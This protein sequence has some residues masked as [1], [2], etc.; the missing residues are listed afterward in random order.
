VNSTLR[1]W[2]TTCAVAVAATTLSVP[3]AAPAQAAAPVEKAVF[4]ADAD[5]DGY[6]GL[7]V[8]TTPAGA[9]T[10]VVAESETSDVSDV[11]ASADGS[12]YVYQ[13]TTFAADGEPL[14][15]KMIVRDVSGRVVRVVSD[16][17]ASAPLLIKP[18]TLSPDGN[19]VLFTTWDFSA[20]V[21]VRLARASVS[22]GVI[23]TV[24]NDFEKG[25]FLNN[26]TV[27]A[28]AL[29]GEWR[30]MPIAGGTPTAVT[31]T[32]PADAY[33]LVV[34]P[35]GDKVAW[36]SDTS[37]GDI[38][39]SD[40]E[41][42]GLS[43]TGGVA[44]IGSA[45]TV[46]TGLDNIQPAFS[47]DG[48]TLSWIKW[49]GDFGPGDVWSSAVTSG[50]PAA[51]PATAG[52]DYDV[53]IVATDDGTAPGSVT[54]KP[55]VLN[56]PGATLS[57]TL[58]S[59]TD[60]SGVVLTRKLGTT[61]QKSVYLPGAVSSYGDTGLALGS[62]YTYELRAVDR[63]GNSTPLTHSLT[64]LKA[65]P[66]VAD[67]ISTTSAK[68]AFPVTFAAA[69]PGNALFYVDY[70]PSGSSTW[71]KWV[72]GASGRARTFGAPAATNVAA[73]TATPGKSYTFR[74]IVKDAFGNTTKTFVN[75]ARAVVPFDQTK[76]AFS[77]GSN[78][79]HSAAYLGSY[80]KLWR[81]TDYA[82]VTLTGNRIQVVG[83]RCS[84][85]GT[86]AIYDNGTLVGTVSSYASTTKVRQVLFAKT[87]S[88]IGT[89]S[90]TIK[91][92]ATAGRPNVMLDGFAIRN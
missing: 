14:R 91:P 42:A 58:P 51:T 1:R 85:C 66:T 62:T 11:S 74:V 25:V 54:W 16:V 89:H 53:A 81:T 68:A 44:T 49:D 18:P 69:A 17:S 37:A 60:L 63:S 71:V 59:V 46:A 52:D 56:G 40:I 6:Y 36:S 50:T 87:Y 73:T 83:W 29:T 67:P 92:K 88:A 31:G 3:L 33:D 77:G 28:Q 32:I 48:L 65:A 70:V 80:R 75:S 8:R 5:G 41:V 57:W 61:V 30:T 27:L 82:K 86:F 43:M 22:T 78:V 20:S 13:Q 35:A 38:S 23:G 10:A 19:T 2:G 76:A 79:Y 4:V 90:F 21:V 72:N 45:A 26:T 12:R 84:T 39:T 34:S 7:Y 55:A 64:A 9:A 47:R 24:T 15:S